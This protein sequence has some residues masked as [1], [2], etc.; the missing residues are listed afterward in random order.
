[1]KTFKDSKRTHNRP[2]YG[3]LYPYSGDKERRKL[4][5]A[6]RHK[7]LFHIPLT[8]DEQD[9]V[10]KT[11]LT[12]TSQLDNQGNVKHG[13]YSSKWRWMNPKEQRLHDIKQ[14]E[15]EKYNYNKDVKPE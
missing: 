9:I 12:A 10:D 15:L 7:L 8:E 14:A 3:E 13:K 5:K 4:M 1:M 6:L 11:G 2:V